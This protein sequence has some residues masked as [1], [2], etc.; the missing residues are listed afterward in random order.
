MTSSAQVWPRD[1]GSQFMEHLRAQ[2]V[3]QGFTFTVQPQRAQLPEFLGSYQPDAIAQKPG[4]NIAVEVKQ[5]A[6]PGTQRSLQDIRRLFEGHPDWQFTVAYIGSNPLKS[7]AIRPATPA[8]IRK[9]MNEVTEL[10]DQG[11]RSAAIVIAWSVLEAAVHR[12]DNEA[13]GRPRTPAMVVQT[14][15]QLG[16][17]E[18]TIERRMRAL[19]ELR[20]K[21]VHGDLDAEPAKADVD[22]VL[23]AIAKTVAEES[24]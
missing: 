12:I 21:I 9:R 11:H 10:F 19:I 16:Y 18:P 6:S 2:Y 23:F 4:I 22:L 24:V 7:L 5:T 13:S 3:E 1:T 20:N 17:I 8:A 14:L 15:A